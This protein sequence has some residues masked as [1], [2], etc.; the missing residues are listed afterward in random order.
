MAD[1]PDGAS[2][3]DNPVSAAP[4]F[5]IGNV[6]VMAGIPRIMQGM[7]GSLAPR[8]EGGAPLL[9]CS[10]GTDLGEGALAEGLSRLQ[11]DF[12]DVMIGSYPV[13][14]TPGQGVKVVMRAVSGSRLE[15]V[16]AEV[17]AL[18][19]RLGGAVDGAPGSS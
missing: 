15:A 11:E 3:I 17:R 16:A 5:Q 18:V 7:F 8:L 19:A 14:A 1:V 10:I 4:G 12:F 2:L 6:F 13:A 9:S